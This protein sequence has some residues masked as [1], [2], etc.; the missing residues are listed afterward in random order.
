MGSA[1]QRIGRPILPLLLPLAAL[2]ACREPQAGR[3]A[4]PAGTVAGVVR[5]LDRLEDSAVV[6]G[7]PRKAGG[8]RLLTFDAGATPGRSTEEHHVARLRARDTAQL[9]LRARP[10]DRGAAL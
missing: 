2:V 6:Q 4:A 7:V 10:L 3:A 5:L 9:R 8:R 1:R